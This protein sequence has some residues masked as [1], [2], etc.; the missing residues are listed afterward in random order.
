MAPRKIWYVHRGGE[1]Y[2]RFELLLSQTGLRSANSIA[3]LRDYLVHGIDQ[4]SACALNEVA[5][6]SNFER[7]LA[8]IN[9]VAEFVAKIEDLDWEKRRK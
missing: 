3:A 1:T 5:N 8:R 2:A 7:D 9:E 4:A 6:R